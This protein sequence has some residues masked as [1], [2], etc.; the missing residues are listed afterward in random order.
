MTP[1]RIESFLTTLDLQYEP[2]GESAWLIRDPERGLPGVLLFL[3]ESLVSIQTRIGAIPAE[4]RCELFEELLRLN[5]DT[6]HGAYAL[7][8]QEVLLLD[9][10]EAETLNYEEFRASLDAVGLTLAQHREPLG[11]FFRAH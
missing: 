9:T 5:A 1:S 4:N 8:D 2:A 10:L 6:V 7:R 11:R 3:E